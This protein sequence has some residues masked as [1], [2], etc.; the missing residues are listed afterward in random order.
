M[1]AVR[2]GSLTRLLPLVLLVAAGCGTTKWSD[3]ARTATEQLLISDA[4]DRAVSDLDFSVLA[5][6][7]V[8]FDSTYLKGSVDENYV[9][10][11]LRQHLLASGCYLME[12]REQADYVVEARAGAVGTDRSDLLLGVP[13]VNVPSVPGLPVAVPSSIPEIPLAKTTNQK[14]VA[15]LAV[16]A[17]NRRTGRPVLQTGIDP[18]VSMARNSWLFG[19][20]PFRKGTIYDQHQA[21]EGGVDIPIIGSREQA[22]DYAQHALPVT[23][24]AV[25]AEPAG[26]AT[27]LAEASPAAEATADAAEPAAA[28]AAAVA[29]PQL[30][31]GASTAPQIGASANSPTELPDQRIARLPPVDHSG[32]AAPRADPLTAP[33]GAGVQQAQFTDPVGAASPY[34]TPESTAAAKGRRAVAPNSTQRSRWN[35]FWPGSWFGAAPE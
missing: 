33:P 6:K 9:V 35:I 1:Q 25:F 23:A 8:Y 24:E 15:K 2:P 27:K 32:M 26:A 34:H 30:A 16:F 7:T 3:T 10:S 18:S 17:Y 12:T 21:L 22:R 31:A 5:D 28:S 20:G 11:S 19:A 13:S 29:T 4:V 14:A